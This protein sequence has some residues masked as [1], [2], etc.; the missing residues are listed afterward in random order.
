MSVQIPLQL[1]RRFLPDWPVL[2]TPRTLASYL[3][4]AHDETGNLKRTFKEW[5]DAPGFPRPDSETGVFYKPAIDAWLAAR[6]GYADP[7]EAAKAD[8]DREFV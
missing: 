1:R 7:Q 8:M 3:D 4:C 2:M 6:F 5:R